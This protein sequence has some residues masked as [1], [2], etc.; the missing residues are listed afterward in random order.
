M[1]R[2]LLFLLAL[3]LPPLA[4]AQP[5]AVSATLAQAFGPE[6]P[7][8]EKAERVH[9]LLVFV[10][11]SDDLVVETGVVP[12]WPAADRR[13]L[14]PFATTLLATSPED[15]PSSDSSLSRYFFEQSRTEPGRPGRL[16]LTGKVHPQDASGRPFV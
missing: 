3:L 9:A 15:I 7:R 13:A 5:G 6:L 16:R 4:R 14:P 1:R 8:G 12:G 10:R 2:T 11:F